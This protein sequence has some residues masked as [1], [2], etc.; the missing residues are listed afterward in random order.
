MVRFNF[1]KSSKRF[2]ISEEAF[3]LLSETDNV[4]RFSDLCDEAHDARELYEI[5][6]Q[7]GRKNTIAGKPI[8]EVIAGPIDFCQISTTTGNTLYIPTKFQTLKN[9]ML[10]G[11]QGA[12]IDIELSQDGTS[13]T[14][15]AFSNVPSANK[16]SLR[17]K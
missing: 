13:S 6:C 8:A 2:I 14:I 7:Y 3:K 4:R 11:L 10:L 1:A 15:K 17:L 5:I 12:H 16:T 9:A